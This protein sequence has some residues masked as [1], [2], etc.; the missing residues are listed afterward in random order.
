MSSTKE[1][2][3]GK[4]ISMRGKGAIEQKENKEHVETQTVC[5]CTDRQLALL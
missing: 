1:I 5:G 3:R 2:V 4:N